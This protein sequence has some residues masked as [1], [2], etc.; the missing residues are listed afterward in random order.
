MA[1]YHRKVQCWIFCEDADS[2]PLCLL[3]KTAENRGSFWQPVTGSVEADENFFAAACREAYEET[4]LIFAA[5][6]DDTGY[7]FEFT[8]RFGPTHERCF[9]ARLST[10]LPPKLDPKE[11]QDFQWIAPKDAEPLLRFPSNIEGL[12][13]SY[14]LLYGKDFT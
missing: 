14:R 10:K 3:F 12:H 5:P 13:Q 7:E 4:G 6:P 8:S 2:T 11:H 9:V 1:K